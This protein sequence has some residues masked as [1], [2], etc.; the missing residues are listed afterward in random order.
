MR[1][2]FYGNVPGNVVGIVGGA[3]FPGGVW[4]VDLFLSVWYND[5]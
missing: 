5:L 3:M 2:L 4:Y 1:K